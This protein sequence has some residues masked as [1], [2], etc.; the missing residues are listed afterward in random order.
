MNLLSNQAFAAE[1]EAAR[2]D[3][4]E[5]SRTTDFHLDHLIEMCKYTNN[6]PLMLLYLEVG[7]IHVF[8]L[9]NSNKQHNLN[10]FKMIGATT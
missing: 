4:R 9:L 1:L 10:L 8:F 2:L 5:D 3:L 6:L 7:S